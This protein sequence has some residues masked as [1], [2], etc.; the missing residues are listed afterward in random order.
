MIGTGNL[1]FLQLSLQNPLIWGI[2]HNPSNN[3]QNGPWAEYALIWV[4]QLL[5]LVHGGRY[6][7]IKK[8]ICT[9]SL[10]LCCVVSS[11]IHA[12]NQ[13]AGLIFCGGFRLE[14]HK[15]LS[16]LSNFSSSKLLLRNGWGIKSVWYGIDFRV[17]TFDSAI[18]RSASL[19][20]NILGGKGFNT[21][22]RDLSC[23][24][25]GDQ[26]FIWACI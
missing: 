14:P 19:S 2:V 13:T 22:Q 5:C 18:V 3:L 23:W 12:T 15:T 4:R 24:G 25:R 6:A 11:C 8:C 9:W 21:G 26:A 16:R 7:V 17:G 10:L 20:E 1:Y